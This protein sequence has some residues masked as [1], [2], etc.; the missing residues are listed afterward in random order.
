MTSFIAVPGKY[1]VHD[2]DVDATTEMTLVPAATSKNAR[3]LETIYISCSAAAALTIKVKSGSTIKMLLLD[4]VAISDLI[5][6]INGYPRPLD[7]NDTITVQADTADV[8]W[9]SAIVA[10]QLTIEGSK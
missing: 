3:V 7:R 1:A 4:A 6:Q 8:F 2:L 10:E 5:Y 9:I